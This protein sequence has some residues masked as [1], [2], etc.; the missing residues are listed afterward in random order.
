[1]KGLRL[2]VVS[3]VLLLGA[4]ACGEDSTVGDEVRTGLTGPGGNRLGERTTTT[5]GVITTTT[6]RAATATT[7]AVT[8]TAPVQ[9]ALEVKIQAKSPQ[10]D[11][12]VGSVRVGSVVRFINT[13]SAPHSVEADDGSFASPIIPP[14][15][16]WDYKTRTAG[17]FNYHDGT[18]PY[19]VG[20]LQVS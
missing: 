2:V 18:R 8:T 12:A 17:S 5:A 7:K 19:A 14:G 4:A 16:H 20:Q 1:M 3:L 6:A 10:F 11:P 13:D 9:V 15:G